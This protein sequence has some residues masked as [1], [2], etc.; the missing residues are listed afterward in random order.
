MGA[1]AGD[2]ERAGQTVAVTA[3]SASDR[4]PRITTPE[5]M[6]A[7]LTWA[8]G[9]DRIERGPYEAQAWFALLE[10]YA[11]DDVKRAIT[12]HY[13]TSRYPVMPADVIHYI[14]DEL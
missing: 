11:R 10:G 4:R 13:R 6:L 5:D 3:E 7:L 2:Q 9:Y 14:E 1:T 12:S 8:A